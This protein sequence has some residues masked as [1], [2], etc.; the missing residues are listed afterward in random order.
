MASCPC[1]FSEQYEACCGRFHEGVTEPPTAETLMRARYTAFVLGNERFLSDTWHASTR[2]TQELLD[3]A[4]TWAGLFVTG[5]VGGGLLDRDG[6]VEF[7][8]RFQRS[9]G[10]VGRVK[11]NSRFVRVDGSWRYLGPA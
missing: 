7:T 2:P 9:D 1:G 4:L 6:T 3:P 11:E 10:T 8:A 5:Q